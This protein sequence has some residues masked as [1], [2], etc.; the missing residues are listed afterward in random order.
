MIFK[1]LTLKTQETVIHKLKE[2]S[3]GLKSCYV[4]ALKPKEYVQLEG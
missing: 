1:S 4:F 2:D 3:I